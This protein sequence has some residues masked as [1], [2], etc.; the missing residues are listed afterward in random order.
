MKEYER[1]TI[2]YYNQNAEQY[3]SSTIDAN[4]NELYSH[5]EKYLN[6]NV[7]LLDLG[8]GTGRDSKHF[9]D[10]GFDVTLVDGSEKMCTC[11][12]K[13]TGIQARQLLF[14]ELDYSDKFDSVW[15]CASLLHLNNTDLPGVI[16][17][18]RIALKPGGILFTCFKYG[19]EEK[20]CN[21]RYFSYFDEIT[22]RELFDVNRGFELMETFITGD[23]RK[24]R[25]KE[26]WVNVIARRCV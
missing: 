23:V 14:E 19:N 12:S 25:G 18:V 5:F 9:I 22:I 2:D 20:E 3:I 13:L 10:K 21:G 4:M 24:G 6:T 11:A 1:K 7:K 15:A 16:E 8:C 26:A 17:K